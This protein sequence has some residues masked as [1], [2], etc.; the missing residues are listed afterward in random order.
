MLNVLGFLAV[1][2]WLFQ[3][4]DDA[5]C[6]GGNDGDLGLTILDGKLD[7]DAKA[8]PVLGGFFGD[9]FTDFLW[10]QTKWTDFGGERAGSSDFA[11][12]DP[13]VDVDHL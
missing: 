7:G 8:F 10:G 5:S 6:G 4:F 1:A 12:G 11:S 9:V 13:D 2:L 3:G